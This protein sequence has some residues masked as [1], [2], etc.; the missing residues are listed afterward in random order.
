MKIVYC[1]PKEKMPYI[2]LFY[3]LPCVEMELKK[4]A[5]RTTRA[6]YSSLRLPPES[7]EAP[8]SDFG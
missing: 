8:G 2:A 5:K 7:N 4:A 3:F 6:R 1:P